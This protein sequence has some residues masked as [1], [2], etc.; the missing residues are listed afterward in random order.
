MTNYKQKLKDISTFIFDVDGVL[1][2]GSVLLLPDGTMS[3]TMN[4]R[5]GYAMQLAIKQGFNIIIITG[6]KDELIKK[7]LEGLGVADIF[8][9]VTHKMDAYNEVL[10]RYHLKPE[11]IIYMGD[12]IPDYEVMT[13][14]GLPTCP[15]NAA[16]E[17]RE[18]SQYISPKNGGEGCVRDIIEQT[19]KIH[20]KWILFDKDLPTSV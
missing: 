19:L 14:V 6:G 11:N 5:D 10:Y 18:I 1:T 9:G 13:N 12:D 2:D 8:L 16:P 4:T 17:I 20:N 7:R 3:R 15:Y